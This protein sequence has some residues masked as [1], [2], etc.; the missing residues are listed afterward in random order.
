M[1][2]HICKAINASTRLIVGK[3][4]PSLTARTHE[5]DAVMAERHALKKEKKLDVAADARLVLELDRIMGREGTA[6]ATALTLE[7]GLALADEAD[8]EE[9]SITS[10]LNRTIAVLS[11]QTPEEVQAEHNANT[12]AHA[13]KESVKVLT[14]VDEKL[15][16]AVEA[17][18]AKQRVLVATLAT[19]IL[20]E[21][22]EYMY[23]FNT[24]VCKKGLNK[25]KTLRPVLKMLE[26]VLAHPHLSAEEKRLVVDALAV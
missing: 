5:I 25:I 13:E 17:L 1:L 16:P 9:D 4:N 3:S 22:A 21:E 2:K 20:K 12:E 6:K 26:E 18:P 14:M 19:V 11:G 15:F 24:Y 8:V 7:Q 23:T 10:E